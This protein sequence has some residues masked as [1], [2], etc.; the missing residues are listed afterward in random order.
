MLPHYPECHNKRGFTR[1]LFVPKAYW[2]DLIFTMP[3][4][5]N[6]EVTNKI[7]VIDNE[8]NKYRYDVMITVDKTSHTLHNKTIYNKKP[9]KI[10]MEKTFYNK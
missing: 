10:F 4:I 3:D 5:A 7:G 8:I 6:I 1:E 2:H 9:V